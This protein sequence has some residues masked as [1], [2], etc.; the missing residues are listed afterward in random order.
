MPNSPFRLPRRRA[1]FVF[2]PRFPRLPPRISDMHPRQ[3]FTFPCYPFCHNQSPPFCG[4]LCDTVNANGSSNHSV[5]VALRRKNIP[6]PDTMSRLL[7]RRPDIPTHPARNM[8]FYP[9]PFPTF[10]FCHD[11]HLLS[12]VRYSQC[13]YIKQSRLCRSS[14]RHCFQRRTR[15]QKGKKRSHKRFRPCT[16][17]ATK[18]VRSGC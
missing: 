5:K 17:G 10:P 9:T 12:M 8:D 6:V 13:G 4:S 18:A 3:H 7:R 2:F 15:A 14:L 11:T 1:L 16:G